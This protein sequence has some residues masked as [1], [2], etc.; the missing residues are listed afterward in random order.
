MSI[1]ILTHT[2]TR[3]IKNQLKNNLQTNILTIQTVIAQSISV[4]VTKIYALVEM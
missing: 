3:R 4:P 2:A 1:T